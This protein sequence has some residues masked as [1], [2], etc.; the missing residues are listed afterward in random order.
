M[1][2]EPTV[3]NVVAPLREEPL[4]NEQG[5]PTIRF[6]EYLDDVANNINEEDV[7]I[8]EFIFS[9]ESAIQQ[10]QSFTGEQTK[11]INNVLE[12]T[13]SIS[14]LVAKESE[15]EKQIFSNQQ[16]L[17]TQNASI[18]SE[19]QKAINTNAQLTITVSSFASLFSETQKELNELRELIVHGG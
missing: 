10:V 15:L 6:S 16:L 9:L 5:N 14:S 8:I 7:N 11:L 17:L 18:E 19:L 13:V 1:Q 3:A 12:L 2:G 4:F